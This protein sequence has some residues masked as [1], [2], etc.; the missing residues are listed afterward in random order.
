MPSVEWTVSRLR[1]DIKYLEVRAEREKLAG[2]DSSDT[3]KV[4]SEYR[5]ALEEAEKL[6]DE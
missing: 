6:R 3:E 4:L 1:E 5:K 2:V